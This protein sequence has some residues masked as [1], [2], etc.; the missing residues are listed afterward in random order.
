M[1]IRNLV[2]YGLLGLASA[3][4]GSGCSTNKAKEDKTIQSV[5]I[6]KEDKSQLSL[7]DVLCFRKPINSEKLYLELDDKKI[8][9]AGGLLG[10]GLNEGDI[11]NLYKL[12]KEFNSLAAG[13]NQHLIKISDLRPPNPIPNDISPNDDSGKLRML[14]RILS[15][16]T[17]QYTD[18]FKVHI[19][20]G[21]TVLLLPKVQS[22]KA[23]EG[24]PV[25][26]SLISL[27]LQEGSICRSN[28]IPPFGDW[29]IKEGIYFQLTSK[30]DASG[31][32]D[33]IEVVI[34]DE[35]LPLF[36]DT[37]TDL[38]VIGADKLDTVTV[39]ASIQ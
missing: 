28:Y 19:L 39:R 38:Y 15:P 24:T 34:R 29:A 9:T 22:K 5:E 1:H 35:N 12:I 26:L 36:I 13:R 30:P 18:P 10:L 4:I 25:T 32:I 6:S 14:H 11:E 27:Q 3:G 23:M 16:G 20:G 33:L 31:F 8:D 37:G 17:I 21:E 2:A 7:K